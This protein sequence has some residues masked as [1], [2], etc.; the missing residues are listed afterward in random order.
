[1]ANNRID[2]PGANDGGVLGLGDRD[3]FL[4][5]LASG[6]PND[7]VLDGGDDS[8]DYHSSI[9]LI[10]DDHRGAAV[11]G[12]FNIPGNGAVTPPGTASS[13]MRLPLNQIVRTR[14]IHYPGGE[15][16][17]ETRN[18][19]KSAR[20]LRAPMVRVTGLANDDEL[21]GEVFY[22]TYTI[23]EP[24]TASCDSRWFNDETGEWDADPGA[25]YDITFRLVVEDGQ[26]FNFN[27]GYVLGGDYG[28]GFGTNGGLSGPVVNQ[29]DCEGENCG[30]VLKA[31]KTTP[32][33]PN[34]NPSTIGG[35]ISVQT[36]WSELEGFSP[37]EVQ[38]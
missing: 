17:E 14:T 8:N 6:S 2:D 30:A 9:Y 33:D 1:V 37:L 22:I 36:G 27:S 3:Q 10:A 12:G 20:P 32:C 11:N 24:G 21:V 7:T 34:Q 23:Y 38:L 28:D 18:F 13:F 19:S 5:A 29:A 26:S 25:T 35:A 4:I 15:V 31:P 16:D